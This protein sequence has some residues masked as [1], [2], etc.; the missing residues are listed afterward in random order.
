M[1]FLDPEQTLFEHF[2]SQVGPADLAD[3][4]VVVIL[5]LSAWSQLGEM[6]GWVRAFPGPKV[7]IDHHVSEDDLGALFFKDTGAEATGTL[8]AQAVRRLG[9]TFTPEI[10]NGL[11]TAIAMDT[12]WFR[13]PSTAPRDFPRR[14]RARRGGG[15]GPIGSTGSCSSATPWAGSD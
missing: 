9:G 15:R 12:G 7:V 14:G 8:V 4:E 6:A 1:T 10:A 13:H 3:R 11:L 2:G 5:D